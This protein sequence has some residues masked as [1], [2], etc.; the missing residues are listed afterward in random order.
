MKK[1]VMSYT[2]KIN[3]IK[4]WLVH[5]LTCS[6]LVAGFFSLTY[7]FKNDQKSAFICLGIAL[8]VDAI[9]GTLARKFN[10]SKYVKNIDGKMLDSVI[11]FFNYIII[12]SIMIF[13]FN[14]VPMSFEIIVPLIILIISAISYSNLNLM[15][16][17]NFYKGFPCIWNILLLYLYFFDLNQIINLILISTCIFLK[18][19]PIKYLHPLRVKKLKIYSIIFMILWFVSSFKILITSFYIIENNFDLLFLSAWLV[20]NIYFISLTFY[21]IFLDI[22]KV[23]SMKINKHEI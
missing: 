12:P 13:W 23:I 7:I 5:L 15:T 21:E 16:S 8:L 19:I 18:F 1:I 2:S 17:D 22:Y 20:S 9:D 6:G 11:D 4:A 14:L 10:V 3:F